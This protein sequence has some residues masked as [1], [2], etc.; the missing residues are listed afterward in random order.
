[1]GGAFGTYYVLKNACRVMMKKSEGNKF[2]DIGIDRRVLKLTVKKYDEMAWT[3]FMWLRV[4]AG[5]G[6]LC[7]L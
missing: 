1:M 3:E 4:G 5:G 7:T 2:G 6:L